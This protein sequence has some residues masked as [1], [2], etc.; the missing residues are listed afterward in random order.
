MNLLADESIDRQIVEKLRQDGYE[1]LYVAELAPSEPDEEVLYRAN[2]LQA[3]LITA[4]KDFGELVYR[5]GRIHAG[6]I[7]LRL[8]GLSPMVKADI[9][10]AALHERGAE[11]IDSFSVVTHA[12][13]RIRRRL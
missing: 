13:I 9:V 8:S 5:L 4:D 7:L 3:V 2:S 6:V 12:T 11:M 10:S 1:V